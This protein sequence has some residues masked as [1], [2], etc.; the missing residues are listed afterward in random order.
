MQCVDYIGN[1]VLADAAVCMYYGPLPVLKNCASQ[2][3]RMHFNA[4]LSKYTFS[5]NLINLSMYCTMTI[6][7]QQNR[8]FGP[9][10]TEM[11]SKRKPHH[12][13]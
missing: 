5:A 11:P 8:V 6:L 3:L 12:C 9:L 1:Q 13:W 7:R 4:T 2:S 10:L